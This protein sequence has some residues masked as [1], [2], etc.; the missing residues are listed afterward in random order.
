MKR[1]STQYGAWSSRRTTTSPSCIAPA[2]FCPAPLGFVE[3]VPGREYLIVMEFMTG[4]I[5]IGDA[6]VDVGI[7]DDA[8]AWF[9][10][11]DAGIA[12]RDIKPSNL[13]IRGRPG[14][15][16]RSRLRAG[17]TEPVAASGG[18][19]EHDARPRLRADPRLVYERALRQFTVAEICEAF[20]ATRGITMPTQLRRMIRQQGR[21]LHAAFVRLLPSKPK[22]IPI[23]RWNRRRV[24]LLA[25]A[26][27]FALVVANPAF[28]TDTEQIKERQRRSKM[29]GA[30]FTNRNGWR[31]RRCQPH[32][33]FRVRALPAGWTVSAGQPTTAG[34]SGSSTTT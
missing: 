16:R 23:Q 18:P 2:F 12:H 11:W 9:G 1:R 20:A 8:S 7:I 34:P 29:P 30:T 22:P 6:D 28:F 26:A 5:E 15:R 19:G 4:A 32:P 17:A 21:D 25:A 3:I 33:A 27:A 13:M 24:L 31:R 14:H 10:A